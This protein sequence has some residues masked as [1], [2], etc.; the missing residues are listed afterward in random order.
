[1]ND[2]LYLLL[3]LIVLVLVV[4]RPLI[5][6]RAR[7]LG[8][9]IGTKAGQQWADSKLPAV[10]EELGTTLV[11]ETDAAAAALVVDT[12]IAARSK[13]FR[14]HGDGTFSIDV[15]EDDDVQ[16]RLVPAGSGTQ[17]QVESFR[18]YMAFPQGMSDWIRLRTQV[19]EAAEEAGVPV[20]TGAVLAYER[21]EQVETDNW[22]WRRAGS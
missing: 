6:F 20:R 2:Y 8:R 19:T 22:R 1:M 17:L 3:G 12:A 16:V 13:K 15:I 14:A 21:H 18:D 9:G 10:L 11:L 5:R 4:F 7:Q